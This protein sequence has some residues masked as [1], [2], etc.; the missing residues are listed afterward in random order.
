MIQFLIMLY[1]AFTIFIT[2]LLLMYIGQF[3]RNNK[4]ESKGDA[5]AFG[6]LLLIVSLSWS[7]YFSYQ[8]YN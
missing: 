7:I 1:L 4:H 6:I 3:I 2:T 5:D 8:L